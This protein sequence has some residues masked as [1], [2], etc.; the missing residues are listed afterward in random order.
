MNKN[1]QCV[2]SLASWLS[3][4]PFRASHFPSPL[5][6]TI[7][8]LE[9]SNM[10]RTENTNRGAFS[11]SATNCL[12]PFGLRYK[13]SNHYNHLDSILSM[14]VSSASM[15]PL[16]YCGRVYILSSPDAKHLLPNQAIFVFS[17][18]QLPLIGS[19]RQYSPRSSCILWFLLF[20]LSLLQRTEFN[21]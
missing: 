3:M 16:R 6:H 8:L 19:R 13:W 11:R 1:I 9:S 5:V 7:S 18:I 21:C 14:T 15:L 2:F 20:S 17:L 12:H 10:H 4:A